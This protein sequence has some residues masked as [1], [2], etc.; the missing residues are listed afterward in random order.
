MTIKVEYIESVTYAGTD[1]G[2]NYTFNAA[3]LENPN[4]WT[5]KH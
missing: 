2:I 1:D 3:S 5:E 4:D